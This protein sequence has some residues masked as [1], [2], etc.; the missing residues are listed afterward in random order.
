MSTDSNN[1][2]KRPNSPMAAKAISGLE[3]ETTGTQSDRLSS[4]SR[5]SSSGVSCKYVSDENIS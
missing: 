3:F 4:I 1:A 5:R 2:G